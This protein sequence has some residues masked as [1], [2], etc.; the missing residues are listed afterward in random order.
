MIGRLPRKVAGG[1]RLP[2]G[3]G[4]DAVIA[5][6]DAVKFIQVTVTLKRPRVTRT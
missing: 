6:P 5:A 1:E 4:T 3:T 2:P